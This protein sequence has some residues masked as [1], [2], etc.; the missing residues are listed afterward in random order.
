MTFADGRQ[1]IAEARCSGQLCCHRF[2]LAVMRIDLILATISR[3]MSVRALIVDDNAEFLRTAR[4][5]LERQG[6]TV[7]AA[8]STT[9]EALRWLDESRPDVVLID[10]DLGE[11]N[12]LDLA[13]S[14]LGRRQEH[15]TRVI[16]IS[17]Y[18]EDDVVDLLESQPAVSFVPK[19]GLSAAAIEAVLRGE[20]PP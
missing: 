10:I 2:L 11:E 18:D 1:A 14:I 5:L 9:Q 12:G 17:A 15:A 20:S 3:T 8:V 19:A 7:V 4:A 16:M 13:N 6:M